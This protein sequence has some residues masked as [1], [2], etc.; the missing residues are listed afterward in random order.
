MHLIIIIDCV[1]LIIIIT[2]GNYNVSV[3]DDEGATHYTI[4]VNRY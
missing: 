4:F 3:V 1:I 2:Q